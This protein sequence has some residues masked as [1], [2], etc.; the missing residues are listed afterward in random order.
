[1]LGNCTVWLGD[2]WS[3]SRCWCCC[4]SSCSTT[5]T[6]SHSALLCVLST[7]LSHEVL[8]HSIPTTLWQDRNIVYYILLI[9]TTA[10]TA[11]TT[12]ITTVS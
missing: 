11:T 6:V 4:R 3:F 10:T 5:S 2:R 9:L 12:T 8:T 7:W 1:L